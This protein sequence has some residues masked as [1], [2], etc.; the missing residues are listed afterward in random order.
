MSKLHFE[1]SL[2][3]Y[4]LSASWRATRT[5]NRVK[6]AHTLGNSPQPP[7]GLVPA[8]EHGSGGLGHSGM[9]Q[10]PP[11]EPVMQPTYSLLLRGVLCPSDP[12]SFPGL[13]ALCVAFLPCLSFPLSISCSQHRSP[14]PCHRWSHTGPRLILS[15]AT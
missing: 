9:T 11:G 4:H 10:I 15:S 3:K 6:S 13:C 5:Q 12:G 8:L 1:A 7:F 2:R 14:T